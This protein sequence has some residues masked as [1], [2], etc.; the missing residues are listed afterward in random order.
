M[1][2][3]ILIPIVLLSLVLPHVYGQAFSEK[4]TFIRTIPVT[5][6]MTLEVINKYGTIEITS[7]NSDSVS[8]RAEIEAFAQNQSKIN[9]M[10]DGIDISITDSKYKV[11][12]QTNFTQTINMLFESFK[13]MTNKLI[14]YD[15][16]VQINYFITI[17]EYLDI[18]IDNKYGDLFM[19]NH[20]GN[21]SVTLANGSL[22]A[23]SIN[24]A[25]DLRLSFCNAIINSIKEG[26]INASFSEITIEE[27]GSLKIESLSSRF[28]TK[29]SSSIITE[30]RRDKY[31]LGTTGSIRGNSYFTD[32]RID[33]LTSEID[34]TARYGSFNAEVI[35]K[36]F[37][38][39]TINSGNS[40]IYL[41][42]EP[43]ASYNIDLSYINTFVTLPGNKADFEKKPVN[44]EK[45]EYVSYGTVG[46]NPG[47]R[48][49]RIEA[50]RGSIVIK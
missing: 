42:F 31:F 29:Y 34:L 5:R 36:D 6:D 1:K 41:S 43:G 11:V 22:K 12:A 35:S 38:L 18:K 4:R 45:K 26:N 33:D 21:I 15:S 46:K 44:E 2:Y 13:G 20:R 10:L 16:R 27:A 37:D 3:R 47:K 7:W 8:V 19:E 17:P 23:N 49:L 30:S 25:S 28:E 40:D 50:N 24:N 9:K 14:P 39:I 48:K 32:F